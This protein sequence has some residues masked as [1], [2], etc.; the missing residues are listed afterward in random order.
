[1]TANAAI[2]PWQLNTAASRTVLVAAQLL[3][4][5]S[6][7]LALQFLMRTTG[8]TLFLFSTIA[9]I[10]TLLAVVFVLGVAAYR[11]LRRHSLFV[12]E[13]VDAGQVIFRQG[14]E[15]DCAYFI[16]SGEVDV[17]RQENGAEKVVA[18]LSKGQ[19]FG[20][21]ALISDA[22]RNA[23]VRAVTAARLAVLGKQ[24]FLTLLSLV[25]R[26]QEDILKTVN[27]RAMGTS[28]K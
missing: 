20:E 4:L 19:Y 28:G 5:V 22:P 11:F 2:K 9:P 14:E 24:N 3:A 26:T 6:F 15:G 18:T 10:L 8:G 23:T 17:V 21:M 27:A 13:N 12:I 7:L 25:P 16:Q 1:M